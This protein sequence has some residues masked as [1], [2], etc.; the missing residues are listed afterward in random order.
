MII[1]IIIDA[2]FIVRLHAVVK[3][4]VTLRN[5]HIIS[6]TP[7]C[8]SFALDRV[9]SL[10]VSTLFNASSASARASSTTALKATCAP[11]ST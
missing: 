11:S 1:V 8:I 4:V 9:A 2:I 3:P 7:A 10:T 6:S 5:T